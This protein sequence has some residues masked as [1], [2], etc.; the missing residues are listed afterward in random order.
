MIT[1][2]KKKN[3]SAGKIEIGKWGETDGMYEAFRDTTLFVVQVHCSHEH[4]DDSFGPIIR[5]VLM[6]SVP[7]QQL[8]HPFTR[9]CLIG[10]SAPAVTMQ[11][12]S[13]SE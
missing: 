13:D 11:Q 3:S 1:G 10:Q 6:Q 7:C 12:Y 8:Y 5:D 9:C 4:Y 2:I